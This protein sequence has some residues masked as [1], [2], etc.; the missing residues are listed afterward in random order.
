MPKYG[1]PS[2]GA[3]KGIARSSAHG[4]LDLRVKL[5]DVG[6]IAKPANAPPPS[7]KGSISYPK[8]VGK[9]SK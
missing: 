9:G 4:C 5:T 2:E 6:R 8:Q 7:S 3:S 1:Y